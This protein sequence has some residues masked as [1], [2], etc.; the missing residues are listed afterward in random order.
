MALIRAHRGG[1]QPGPLSLLFRNELEKVLILSEYHSSRLQGG[2]WQRLQ[3]G[4]WQPQPRAGRD[5]APR[6]WAA[7]LAA[8][9]CCLH[10]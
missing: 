2:A 5:L 1:T 7:C 4:A 8:C 9:L 10:G 6:G 3:G